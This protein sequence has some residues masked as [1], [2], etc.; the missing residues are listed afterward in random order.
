M[1][2]VIPNRDMPE[3][4][5]VG[6]VIYVYAS[7]TPYLVLN[8]DTAKGVL[9]DGIGRV[10]AVTLCGRGRLPISLLYADLSKGQ[11]RL[12]KSSDYEIHIVE[13]WMKK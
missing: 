9:K 6:D 2:V 3:Q 12:F 5:Q 8:T 10:D 13:K 11:A 1:K 7:G 4:V